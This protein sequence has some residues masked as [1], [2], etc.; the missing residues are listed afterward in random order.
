MNISHNTILITGAT[1][2][3]GYEMAMRFAQL[4]NTVIAVGRNTERLAQ[5]KA[6]S[7]NIHP[8]AADLSKAAALH[9]IAGFVAQNFPKLNVLINN[10]G[11]QYNYNIA[12]IGGELA[13]IDHEISLNLT[14]PLQ[15]IALLLPNL[16]QQPEAAIVNVSSGLGLVPKQ[17]A[18][19]YCGTKAGLHLFTKAL[20]YQ[21]ENTNVRVMEVIPPLVDTPM[22]E[23]RGR[24]KIS[25]QQLVDE[26]LVGF[27]NNRKEMNIGKVKILRLLQRLT[28]RIADGLLK[29]G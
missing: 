22:T 25:P 7:A 26:F 16:L 11:I 2:G 23:G 24:G 9:D 27:K 18:P 5:L 28:P 29:K 13:K 1:S 17:A 14:H 15:L 19:V 6:A 20:G 10:A 4:G 8:F 12:E 3:I 21:L